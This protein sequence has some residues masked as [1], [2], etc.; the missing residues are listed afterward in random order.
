MRRPKLIASLVALL[1][2]L[3]G[4]VL[5]SV[6]GIFLAPLINLAF[7]IYPHNLEIYSLFIMSVLCLVLAYNLIYHKA[8][9]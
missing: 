5:G 9:F 4:I 8:K 2:G 6:L 1:A 3:I 7:E